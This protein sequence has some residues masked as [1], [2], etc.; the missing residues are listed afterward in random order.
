MNLL[1]SSSS[2]SSFF[3]FVFF[4]SAWQG[5]QQLRSVEE[6]FQQKLEAGE[7]QLRS[8]E[9]ALTQKLEAAT[10]QA[11][12]ERRARKRVE[13]EMGAERGRLVECTELLQEQVGTAEAEARRCEGYKKAFEDERLAV[14]RERAR[15]EERLSDLM[16]QEALFKESQA[17]MEVRQQ[18][19]RVCVCMCGAV[20]GFPLLYI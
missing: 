11:A 16:K 4:S 14:Q 7:Q 1:P 10:R 18:R 12:E 8:V 2:S 17:V 6:A 3:F 19:A 5:E 9:G 20:R 15:G 13:R